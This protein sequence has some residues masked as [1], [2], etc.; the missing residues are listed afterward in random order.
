MHTLAILF[1]LH[2]RAA[3]YPY[4]APCGTWRYIVI[5]AEEEEKGKGKDKGEWDETGRAAGKDRNVC[6]VYF[7]NRVMR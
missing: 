1:H 4:R 3:Q 5:I 6:S 2:R 7:Y